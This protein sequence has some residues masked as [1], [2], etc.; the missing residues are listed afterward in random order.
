MLVRWLRKDH[1]VIRMQ[2][3]LNPLL[4]PRLKR[5]FKYLMNYIWYILLL[6]PRAKTFNDSLFFFSILVSSLDLSKF[7]AEHYVPH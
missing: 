4:L 2:C 7:Y 3:C 6:S 5:R 1:S